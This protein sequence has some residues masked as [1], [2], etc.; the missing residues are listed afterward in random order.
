[1][2]TVLLKMF[3]IYSILDGSSI[4][5]TIVLDKANYSLKR[6]NMYK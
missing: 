5:V 3:H 4:N 2:E 6:K 1:M